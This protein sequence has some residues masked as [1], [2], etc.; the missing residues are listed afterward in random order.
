MNGARNT[1]GYPS[2]YQPG[3]WGEVVYPRKYQPGWWGLEVRRT[4]TPHPPPWKGPWEPQPPG[5]TQLEAR[6][7]LRSGAGWTKTE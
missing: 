4:P 6:G 1:F 7:V 5:L 3:R 2:S